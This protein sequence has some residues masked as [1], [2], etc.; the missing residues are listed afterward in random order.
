MKRILGLLAIMLF[1][2]LLVTSSLAGDITVTD[3]WVREAPPGAKATAAYMTIS[4]TSSRTVQLDSAASADF[5]MIE[6]HR[7]EMHDGMAHMKKQT[8]IRIEAGKNVQL[9][10]GDFHLM[11][12]QPRRSLKTGD[13]CALQ[14][15]FDNGE[16]IAV[17][18]LV[19]KQ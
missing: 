16:S 14:L 4:N 3:P 17:Q 1:G 19:R 15:L 11:L 7:T 5:G 2:P 8:G 9:K 18:A 10:P 13:Q 12:M 6:M